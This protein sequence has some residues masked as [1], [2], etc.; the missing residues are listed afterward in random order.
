MIRGKKPVWAIAT[1]SGIVLLCLL[2]NVVAPYDPA[3]MDSAS[4]NLAPSPVHP[5]GTD[6]MGRDLLSLVLYGGRASLV[7]G[8]L[9]SLIATVIAVLYGTI[10]GLAGKHVDGFLMRLADLLLSVPSI[11]LILFLQAMWGR[12]TY[13][14]L[15]IVIGVTSWMAIA[16]IIRSEVRKIGESDYILAAKT[17]GADFR[18]LLW[19]HLLPNYVSSILYMVVSNIGAAMIT[20][21]TLSFMGLGLPLTTLS[22]GSLLSMSEQALL[23][24]RWWIIVIPGAVLVLT[25]IAITEIGEY[26]RR[27]INRLYSNL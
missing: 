20:E 23:S 13:L 12:A 27:R 2:A 16:K 5:F 4:I 1:F 19:R 14:S 9:A 18:Y 10:A 3:A 8:L 21:S 22:W 6:H 25:L 26:I 11:L 15:S 17:M 24:D 7:I